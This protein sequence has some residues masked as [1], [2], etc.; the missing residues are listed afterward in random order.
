M[1][2][3]LTLVE[4]N[5]IAIV[6]RKHILEKKD[7]LRLASIQHPDLQTHRVSQGV[8]AFEFFLDRYRDVLTKGIANWVSY[9]V[10]WSKVSLL[11]DEQSRSNDRL[12]RMCAD[13]CMNTAEER[14]EIEDMS[15]KWKLAELGE[16]PP[17]ENDKLT[18]FIYEIIY[19]IV[20]EL[21]RGWASKKWD[22]RSKQ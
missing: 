16:F 9:T 21:A 2:H 8:Y 17:I 10:G 4:R 1:E 22:N 14:G 19:E 3:R 12:I 18:L 13:L 7:F 11:I 20:R 5:S 15:Q 6:L